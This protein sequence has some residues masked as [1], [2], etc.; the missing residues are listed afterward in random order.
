MT[1][2]LHNLI[3]HST[4]EY[5]S[6]FHPPENILRGLSNAVAP[7]VKLSKLA[8]PFGEGRGNTVCLK[9]HYLS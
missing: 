9:S 4:Y 7:S 1:Y 5:I 3:S 2:F 8:N 6:V